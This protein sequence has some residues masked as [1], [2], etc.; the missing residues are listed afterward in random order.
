MPAGDEL[1]M[2]VRSCLLTFSGS[3][4]MFA[5]ASFQGDSPPPGKCLQGV[6]YFRHIH[7]H[8]HVHVH[9]RCTH[10]IVHAMLYLTRGASVS[11]KPRQ[12]MKLVGTVFG[13]CW[14]CM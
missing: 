3:E 13:T 10:V 2:V 14:Q 11:R 6:I 1:V 12:I 7:V 8:V 5:S 9:V 4:G